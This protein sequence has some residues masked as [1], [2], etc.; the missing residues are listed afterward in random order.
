MAPSSFLLKYHSQQMQRD[1]NTPMVG[2][3]ALDALIHAQARTVLRLRPIKVSFPVQHRSQQI[4]RGGNVLVIG[5]FAVDASLHA[6][7]RTVL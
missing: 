5:V 4:R 1:G 2:M 7:A 6:Q 3:F